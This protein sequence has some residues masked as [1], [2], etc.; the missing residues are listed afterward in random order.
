MK[1]SLFKTLFLL[2][3]LAVIGITNAADDEEEEVDVCGEQ[4]EALDADE[5][6]IAAK[7]FV[8]NATASTIIPPEMAGEIL[9]DGSIVAEIEAYTPDCVG[10]NGNTT[11]V[12][13]FDYA[14]ATD[15]LEDACTSAGGTFYAG[16]ARLVCQTNAVRSELNYLNAPMCVGSDCEDP[17]DLFE[18]MWEGLAED[19]LSEVSGLNCLAFFDDVDRP[20]P[21]GAGAVSYSV[22][23]LVAGIAVVVF[24]L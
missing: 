5:D 23:L 9:L 13:R 12:C 1:F 10:T 21:S 14:D 24:T 11:L 4:T 17:E 2:S 16:N 19:D 3:C 18:E 20:L 15:A 8:A 22:A 6:I 7:D